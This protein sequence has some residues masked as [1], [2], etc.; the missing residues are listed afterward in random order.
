MSDYYDGIDREGEMEQRL[1]DKVYEWWDSLGEQ[2][3]YDLILDWYPNELNEDDDVDS[4]FGDMP[5][6]KQLWIWKRENNLTDED[7]EGQRDMAGDWDIHRRLE[8]DNEK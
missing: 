7:I 1:M 6:E 3:Q 8:G 2:E 4:F 5:N